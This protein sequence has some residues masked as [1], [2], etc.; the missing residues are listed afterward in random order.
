[1]CSLHKK[2]STKKPENYKGILLLSVTGKLFTEL[3][4]NRLNTWAETHGLLRE[5]QA[6]Y[7]KGYST[8]DQIF[9]LNCIV[10]KYV[11][12][13]KGRFYCAFI[14]FSKA[15][16][17]IPQSCTT[18]CYKTRVH[19]KILTVLKSLYSNLNACARTKEGLTD[20]FECNVGT[21][22]GCI[23][24]PF[25]F[26]MYMNEFISMLRK[27][28][29]RGIYVNEDAPSVMSLMY[30]D[31][32]AQCSDTCGALQCMLNTLEQFCNQ[33]GLVVNM[34]KTVYQL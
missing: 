24:S 28:G 12:K 19:G 33:L 3:L 14:D 8:V 34:A 9:L 18:D 31:D 2:C 6:G 10:E 27:N 11:A 25:L 26:A 16:D 1:M 17:S 22:Q 15:F 23:L 30:A 29:C 32:L 21:G 4:N 5:E 7:G 13:K 20:M